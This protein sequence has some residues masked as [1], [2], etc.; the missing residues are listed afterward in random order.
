MVPPCGSSPAVLLAALGLDQE[1]L[2][3]PD[4][5]G[6]LHHDEPAVRRL[7]L[8]VRAGSAAGGAY[9]LE[10]PRLGRH[11]HRRRLLL[12]HVHLHA[13][14]GAAAHCRLPRAPAPDAGFALAALG[15][16]QDADEDAAGNDQ[17]RHANHRPVEEPGEG[18]HEQREG[19]G[20]A[21]ADAADHAFRQGLNEAH[22]ALRQT[23]NAGDHAYCIAKF[24]DDP[25]DG[26]EAAVQPKPHDEGQADAQDLQQHASVLLCLFE[27]VLGGDSLV[28]LREVA[29]AAVEPEARG[30]QGV[31]LHQ[32]PVAAAHL[33]GT[34]ND[35]EAPRVAL[36]DAGPEA[37]DPARAVAADAAARAALANDTVVAVPDGAAPPGPQQLLHLHN[38]WFLVHMQ[39]LLHLRVLGHGSFLLLRERRVAGAVSQGLW[40][41]RDRE[42]VPWRR[43]LLQRKGRPFVHRAAQ[44]R[45]LRAVVGAFAEGL[46]VRGRPLG[47]TE[48]LL[49]LWQERPGVWRGLELHKP[50]LAQLAEMEGARGVDGHALLVFV[51]S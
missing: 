28:D 11:G 1:G 35:R 9:D 2:A 42:E 49:L 23:A 50:V 30:P 41:R 5:L 13:A 24:A 43:E 19:Q 16:A 3:L 20:T 26:R 22:Q 33:M 47:P 7:H 21:A 4:S 38:S 12:R 40:R 8:D 15:K 32:L 17:Q 25:D 51:V 45:P 44:A 29:A 31:G 39:I 34:R 36:R 14:D 18:S 6:H 37:A 27:H 48:D 46:Q 10:L